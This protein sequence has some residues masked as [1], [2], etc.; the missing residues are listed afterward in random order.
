MKFLSSRG[1]SFLSRQTVE[2]ASE[3][4]ARGF[5]PQFVEV[6]GKSIS[7]HLLPAQ[8]TSPGE[9]FS[10]PQASIVVVK[11]STKARFSRT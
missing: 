5:S 11:L 1:P 3:A 6:P 4:P 2:N 7:P 8:P 9:Y 10:V